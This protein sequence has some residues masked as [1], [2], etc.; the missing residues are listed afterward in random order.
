MRQTGEIYQPFAYII[1]SAVGCLLAVTRG[2][3]LARVTHL[4]TPEGEDWEI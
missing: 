3:W 4:S 1:S 2:V